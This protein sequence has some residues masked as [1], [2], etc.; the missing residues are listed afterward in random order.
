MS[1]SRVLV[2][3]DH[4][5]LNQLIVDALSARID[6]DLDILEMELPWPHEPF[7][8]VAEVREAS[9]CE[10][11][12]AAAVENVAIAITQVAPFT[13]AVLSS[14][15]SLRFI[16][17]C[18]GGPV[19]V[20]VAAASRAGI[21]VCATPGRNAIATAE[22][23]IAILMAALRQVPAADAS[24]RRGEWRSD[25]YAFSSG[26]AEVAGTTVGLVGYGAVGRHVRNIVAGFGAQVLVFDP[27]LDQDEVPEVELVSLPELLSRSRIVSLHARLTAQSERLIGADELAMLPEGAVL[28]NAAR[29]GLLDY[30]A[31]VDALEAGQ[32]AAAGFDVSQITAKAE[33]RSGLGSRAEVMPAVDKQFGLMSE[34]AQETALCI[35]AE[36]LTGR[37]PE[38]DASTREILGRHGFQF[39]AGSFIPARDL[40][41][42]EAQ[43]MSP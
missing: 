9:D 16:V 41:A 3:G 43:F 22:H 7:G 19:N 1:G 5:V 38:L 11:E 35:L 34:P 27:Y 15:D 13:E 36:R 6:Q 32:L 12:I 42:R 21:A 40:D 23:T 39:V 30:D 10:A 17:C 4:F 33:A 25:L 24:V 31:V 18:R 14:A 8:T 2:A 26:G 20:N 29:A 37:N 28:V